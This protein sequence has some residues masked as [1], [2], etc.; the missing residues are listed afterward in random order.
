MTKCSDTF[1]V[2]MGLNYI[3]ELNESHTG[4]HTQLAKSHEGRPFR[5][6]WGDD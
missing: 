6:S 1:V 3:C 2:G 4:V 5:I